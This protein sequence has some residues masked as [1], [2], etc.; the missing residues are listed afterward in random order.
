MQKI[1][2]QFG[3]GLVELGQEIRLLTYLINASLLY[4]HHTKI[5]VLTAD[6][7]V[8]HFYFISVIIIFI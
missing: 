4:L 5:F 2:T 7:T 3:K 8:A 1:S 6:D